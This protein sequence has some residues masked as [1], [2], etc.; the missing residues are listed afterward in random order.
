MTSD[1]DMLDLARQLIDEV[2]VGCMVTIGPDGRPYAR[3]MGAAPADDGLGWVYS[4]SA[5]A[6]HKVEHIRQQPEVCW[7]FANRNYQDVVTLH[8][9][10]GIEPTADMPASI[11]DRLVEFARPYAVNV[12]TDP[13]HYQFEA[14]VTRVETVELLAPH[15]GVNAPYTLT[16]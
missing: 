15:L 16:L 2:G 7:V 12:L 8:G 6:T 5:H 14:V 10:A 13:H 3:Y 9:K 1:Q 11:Y 4:L